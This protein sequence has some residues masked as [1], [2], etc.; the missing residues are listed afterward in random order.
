MWLVKH[1]NILIRCHFRN[2]G[3]DLFQLLCQ[4]FICIFVGAQ[5]IFVF[6]V[7]AASKLFMLCTACDL[8]QFFLRIF[9]IDSNHSNF[10]KT[11]APVIIRCSKLVNLCL[12]LLLGHFA[13]AYICIFN[14]ICSVIPSFI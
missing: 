11:I 10:C 1:G 2:V 13:P 4:L 6:P 7:T 12:F 5:I 14:C 8:I 9:V 3:F